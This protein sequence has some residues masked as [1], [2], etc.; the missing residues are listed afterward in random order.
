M[1]W[2]LVARAPDDSE[3]ALA[4]AVDVC[5]ALAPR[6]EQAFAAGDAEALAAVL[7]KYRNNV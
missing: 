5:V 7:E 2:F 4:S 6:I 3:A 1:P